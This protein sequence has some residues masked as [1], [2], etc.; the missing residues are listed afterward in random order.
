VAKVTEV[1]LLDHGRWSEPARRAVQ[2]LYNV[3]CSIRSIGKVLTLC[4]ELLGVNLDG[5]P[6]RR[7]IMRMI[8]EGGV[9]AELQMIQELMNVNGP[10]ACVQS[11]K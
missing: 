6:S 1:C 7:S 11:M 8:L 5:V 3:G 9:L 4:S 10:C 2:D